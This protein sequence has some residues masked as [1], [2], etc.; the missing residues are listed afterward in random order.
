MNLPAPWETA[1]EDRKA[2]EKYRKYTKSA[3]L[4]KCRAEFI[5]RICK[6]RSFQHEG[7]AP[8]CLPH[9]I[10]DCVRPAIG[11]PERS[12]PSF[13]QFLHPLIQNV[14]LL[15]KSGSRS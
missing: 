2:E 6:C 7:S 8:V 9:E 12:F 15:L 10:R 14:Y 3:C 1:C 11:K 4:M 13:A 5:V